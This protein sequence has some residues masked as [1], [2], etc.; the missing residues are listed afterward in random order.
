VWDRPE[1]ASAKITRISPAV[2]M[3]SDRKCAPDARCVAEMETAPRA[4]IR[5]AATAPATHPATWAGR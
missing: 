3:T 4:N 2:A 1:R 5:F